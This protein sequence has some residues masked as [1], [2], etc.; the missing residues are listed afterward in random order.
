MAA[1]AGSGVIDP[2]LGP[3]AD[4]GGPTQTH[5]LLLGSP[6][7]DAGNSTLTT[8][9]RGFT[10][11]VDLANV[12][13]VTGGNGA[14]IGAFELQQTSPSCDFDGDFDCDIDDIDAMVMEIAAGTNSSAFDL[15]GDGNVDLAD[16][17]QWLADAGALNLVSGNPYL[18]ADANLDGVVDGSDFLTWNANKFTATGKWSQG[19]WNADGVTDGQDFLVWNVNKFQSSDAGTGVKLTLVDEPDQDRKKRELD[20]RPAAVDW[21]FAELQEGEEKERH[22]LGRTTDRR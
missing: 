11:P 13:N 12:A 6:A 20:W 3:L 21:L 18:L 9:Q 14:D 8:D 16:R 4:N 7:L 1:A 19:D 22:Y 10:R 2:L 15:T 17:D 5:A